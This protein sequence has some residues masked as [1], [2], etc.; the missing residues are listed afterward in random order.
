[1]P[2]DPSTQFELRPGW[3]FVLLYRQVALLLSVGVGVGAGASLSMAGYDDLAQRFRAGGVALGLLILMLNVGEWLSR[4]YVVGPANVTVRAGLFRRIGAEVPLR[5]IQHLTL[6]RTLGER[7]LGV[8]TLGIATAGSD[9]PAIYLLHVG[10]P[11]ARLGQIRKAMARG[12]SPQAEP[13]PPASAGPRPA[14]GPRVIGLS[15]GIGSGKSEVARVFARR[16]C[17]VIDSDREAK[18]ALDRPGVRAELLRWWGAGILG[19]DG[20]VDRRKVAQIVFNDPTQRARLEGLVHPL[21]KATRAQMIAQADPV[22]TRAIIV[23]A[24]LLYEAG[25]D[26]ECDAIVFV[27]APREQRLARVRSSRG[28]DEAELE[29]REKAQL[30]VEEKRQ[31]A[32]EVIVNDA[33]LEVLGQAA[34]RALDRLLAARATGG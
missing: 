3:A 26:K 10:H 23:D 15:G 11:E 16:G 2:S 19:A 29:R 1:M 31:R 33:G 30:P 4:R 24:P 32:D 21:V 20:K 14:R 22:R 18:A 13:S 25:L 28:W 34:E 17:L 8:G 9:G 27:D 12:E 7:L 5:N 6:T